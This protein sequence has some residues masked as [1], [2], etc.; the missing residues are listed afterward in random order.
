MQISRRLQPKFLIALSVAFGIAQAGHGQAVDS[1]SLHEAITIGRA[2]HPQAAAAEAQQEQARAQLQQAK[3]Q[4]LPTLSASEDMTYS[5]DPVFAF[6]SKLR[7]ARFGSSDFDIG[8]L[9]HPAALSNF[10]A[11]VT[12]TWT[13]FDGGST[14][15]RVDSA[16]TSQAAAELNARYSQEQIASEITRLYYRVLL[17][18]DQVNVAESALKRAREIASDIQDRVHSG[19]SLDSDGLR[20]D[21]ALRNAEDDLASA[22]SNVVLARRDL[23]DAI[24][25]PQANR[26]L[27]SPDTQGITAAPNPV[28]DSISPDARFDLRAL[29]LQQQAAKQTVASIRATAWPQVSTYGHVENDAEHVVTDGSGNWMIGAKVEIHVFDGGARRAQEHE[30]EAQEHL[31]AAQERET[32]LAARAAI[33]SLTQQIDDLHRRFATADAAIRVQQETLQTA[34]DR[35]ATGLASITD[36]LSGESDLSGAEFARARI[37]YQLCIAR[38]ELALASGS[39][40]TSKAGQP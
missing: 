21:L 3:A 37:F 19:L 15:Q 38:T 12:A 14:R 4:R 20:S 25:S 7:Q 36:V 13:A 23:F 1:L 27:V 2:H 5:D 34:R 33:G 28:T 10:S 18:Q 16:R 11:S 35:Y 30:A 26:P 24:G 22:Q 32:A 40:L 6:G 9:N 39:P 8:A 29:R 17:A 31:L